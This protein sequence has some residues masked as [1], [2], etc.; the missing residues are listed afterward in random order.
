MSGRFMSDC[1]PLPWQNSRAVPPAIDLN[2]AQFK[3][4]TSINKPIRP[5]W[6]EDSADSTGHIST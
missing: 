3:S 4:L 6:N 2:Q 1:R 5:L